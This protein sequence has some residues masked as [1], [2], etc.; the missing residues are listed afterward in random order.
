MPFIVKKR[1][2]QFCVYT[3]TAPGSGK[4]KGSPHGCHD[5]E[6]EATAQLRA[7]YANVPEARKKELA[8]R[9]KDAEKT[10][11][12]GLLL[13]FGGPNGGKDLEGEYFSPN[14]E[15]HL[16]WYTTRPLLYAHGRD[17]DGPGTVPIGTIKSIEVRD[18]GGWMEAQLDK[19]SKY[20]S[21][22]SQLVDD[23]RLFLSSGSLA[24]LVR[25]DFKTGELLRWP[26]VE[27]T[28][29]PVPANP[30]AVVGYKDAEAHFQ[31][32]GLAEEWA[33]KSD[34]VF[35]TSDGELDEWELRTDSGEW[36][37]EPDD[38]FADL[39]GA[40]GKELVIPALEGT[41]EQT[42][43]ELNQAC[44]SA[45]RAQPGGTA[46]YYGAYVVGTYPDHVVVRAFTGPMSEAGSPSAAKFFSI[47]YTESEMGYQLGAPVE[48]TFEVAEKALTYLDQSEGARDALLGWFHR[49]K[50][51]WILW[52]DAS[53]EGR[54]ITAARRKR[55]EDWKDL[56]RSMSDEVESML[57]EVEPPPKVEPGTRKDAIAAFLDQ[58]VTTARLTADAVVGAT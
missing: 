7:M 37:G 42:I 14:T 51:A 13:P 8:V 46:D 9:F 52:A 44:R 25:K 50:D 33:E 26:V 54:K 43:E 28:M 20:W 55:L 38:T 22:I 1:G 21:Y 4:P 36:D 34:E 40:G 11:L 35:D 45:F 58:Y 48:V 41:Y 15:F 6:A 49:T 18:D 3:E 39:T 29:T 16:D 27:G 31:A 2:S 19:S 17:D 47:D 32:V 12:E 56:L 23:G 24:H 57:D 53:K 5:S 30:I 10:L